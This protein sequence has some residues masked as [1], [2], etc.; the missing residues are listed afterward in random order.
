MST[1]TR[2]LEIPEGLDGE[3]VDAALARALGLSRTMVA[4]AAE[5]GGIFV[6]GK[7]VDKSARLAAGDLIE[8]EIIQ[9]SSRGV[10]LDTA[11]IPELHIVHS[12]EDILVI[13]KPLGVAA[14]PSIGWSGPTVVGVLT[15]RGVSLSQL[16]PSE[17]AGI[18]HRLDVGTSGLMVVA[19]SDQAY[20]SL[21]EQF[22]SR[23]VKKIYHAIVQGHPDP[24]RG[25]IDAPIDR[26]PRDEFKFA[27]VA[28]G[29]PSI[30]HYQTLESF[31][32][33]TLVE[34]ELETGRTHQIRVHFAAL[35][36]PLVGDLMYGADPAFA[37]SLGLTRQWLHAHQ[38]TFTHPGSGQ[39][40][41]FISA[42]PA[43][44]ASALASLRNP[45]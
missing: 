31:A 23:Q 44:L 20:I 11:D 2:T 35:R 12:D 38:L 3:R 32:G 43:D 5:R 26:H 15:A 27:V 30:T 6:N 41:S 28:D 13:D 39:E 21:K 22:R 8:I 25:T 29:K 19:K 37:K 34:V 16:A 42:Y 18:V 4:A 24:T 10:E 1:H 17:R 33:A 9:E 45:S 7:R 40:V 14:H 36:H